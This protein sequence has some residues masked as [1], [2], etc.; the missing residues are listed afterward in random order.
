MPPDR[1]KGGTVMYYA[2]TRLLWP[3]GRYNSEYLLPDTADLRGLA[4]DYS[5]HSLITYD[6][7]ETKLMWISRDDA[8]VRA[9][10]LVDSPVDDVLG[11]S[12]FNDYCYILNYEGGGHLAVYTGSL[13]Q[14]REDGVM[15][16]S[17]FVVPFSDRVPTGR[18]VWDMT[19]AEVTRYLKFHPNYSNIFNIGPTV[20]ILAGLSDDVTSDTVPANLGQY[21]VEFD[22]LGFF[23]N[24]ILI[25]LS[26]RNNRGYA[27]DKPNGTAV[28][29][30]YHDGVMDLLCREVSAVQPSVV[31]SLQYRENEPLQYDTFWH[32][33]G[34]VGRGSDILAAGRWIYSLIGNRIYRSELIMIKLEMEDGWPNTTTLDLG[35]L[36]SGQVTFRKVRCKNIAPVTTYYD[37][38]VS[39][40]DSMLL[41]SNAATTDINRYTDTI[42]IPGALKP[43][44]TFTFYVCLTAPVISDEGFTPYQYYDKINF[45]PL[46]KEDFVFE[47]E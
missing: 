34:E 20:Y 41:L 2:N 3:L 16:L 27:I 30:T 36:S 26:A 23:R 15:R 6:R 40:R 44:D 14:G 10:C 45:M 32:V 46:K 18:T 42:S 39:S 38:I 33:G 7:V 37:M 13:Q 4:Y 43:G 25:D 28:A 47:E 31:H 35:N 1:G 19:H 8:S 21:I 9:S 11:I 24:P 29:C 12:Q 17:K 5:D 22:L